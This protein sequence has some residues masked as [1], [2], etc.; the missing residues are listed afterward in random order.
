MK[1]FNK[2]GNF[3]PALAASISIVALVI[4]APVLAQEAAPATPAADAPADAE[5]TVVV[6]TGSRL[7]SRGF[8]APTPVTIVDQQELK[9]SGT[10]NVDVLL[11]STPQFTGS[12]LNSPTANT[13]Q[14]GQPIGTATLNLRNFGASRNLVLVNGRRFAITGPDFTTDINTIPAA[15]IKRVEVVTGGSS[16]VY[17]S[18]AITGVVNFVMRDDFQG[19]E[20]QAQRSWDEHTGTPTYSLSLTTGGNFA[21][22]RGNFV[23]SIDYLNRGGYTR[24]DRGDW[25]GTSLGDG[26]VTSDSWSKD[27][28]GTPLTVPAGETCLEA[29]GRPG[30]VY[31]G[32][33]TVPN[34]RIGNLPTVGSSSSNP[35]LDAALVAAG[36]QNMTTLGAVFSADGKT[37]RPYE[38]PSDSYDLGPE[39]YIITPQTRWMGNV[40]AHYDF[41]DKVTGYVEMHYSDNVADVQIAPTSASGNFLVDTDNPNLSAEMQEVLNQLDLKESGTTSVTTGSQT[42]TTTP[43]DGLAVLN[44][45]RRFS[46]LGPRYSTSDH[47]VFRTA[48]GVRGHL[49]DVSPDFLRD[50]KYDVYYSFA[51]T[52]ES[53]TQTGSI[54]LSRFQN[55]I[56]SQNGADP[57][58][59]PF[60]QNMTAA[61]AAAISITSNAGLRAEQQVLAGNLTG[62]A[63]DLPA[64]PV[65]FSTGFEWRYDFAKYIPDTY[66][67][68]GD[69]SGWNAAKATSGS[70]MVKEIYGEVRVPI[71]ADLPMAKRL[72]LNGA[73]RFS[74]YNLKGVGSVWTYSL[75][76]EWALNDD[77]TLRAQFQHAIRAPNVGELYGGA[78]TNGP[79][80][81]DPC[82]SR[83]PTAQ[84]TDAV[85]QVCIATGVPANLVFDASIQP[86]N[87][88]TQVTG[89][90]PDLTAETS[91]TTTFGVVYS[92]SYVRGL[93]LSVDYY[94]ITLDDAISTLGGGSLQNVLNLCYNTI[95]DADSVYCKA[96]HRDSTGQIAGPDYVTTTNANIGGIL[97]SGVDIEGHYGFGTSWGLI[98]SSRWD[99]STNLNYVHEYTVTPIQELPDI[100]NRCVGSFG[101]TCGQPIPHWK[102]S[103][104]VTWR[105]GPL[106]LSASARYIGKVT[107]D[108][109]VL[110]ATS[111]GTPPA[112]NTL[113]N[114]VIDPQTYIDLTAAWD[115]SA[116]LQ[117][118]VGA[119]NIFDKDPPI[120]GSSQLSSD[121]TIPATYDVQGRVL[122]VSVDAKF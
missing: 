30:L 42:L 31:S 92:P 99:L 81:T 101:S 27:S 52:T 1:K 91:D 21:E 53:D 48:V 103:A 107:V 85:R 59:N 7:S 70:T 75:G 22:G 68:S 3:R 32:S 14:A 11:S 60:G 12:Q 111:G 28:A 55:A 2:T 117:L 41:N 5:S 83:Q 90:N 17:G 23:A 98:G 20:M 46:D 100:K 73:F 51:R 9:L 93:Q 44:L 10:Q 40:F 94:R 104:R 19:V 71:L 80:A 110:P 118:S 88:L 39:S 33:A 38:S 26:C 54:S 8:K 24:A 105:T 29:G 72:S 62:E 61:C 113:T 114:P 69:V 89:G 18:D 45:N 43:G 67:A 4:A 108:T 63:F 79:S 78:G 86:S 15:L 115:I 57:V 120:L 87:Y 65:D 121:N 76:S 119:R 74:D 77:I 25:A 116:K 64:G 47:S 58:C 37:V 49:G 84:Q 106:T 34:G 66:L 109:Y 35:A 13:V 112:L 50:L 82:S 122:F 56:L 95:Q 6:V 102:G 16:A 97:T 36:L 96:I